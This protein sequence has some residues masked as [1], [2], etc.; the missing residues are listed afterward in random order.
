MPSPSHASVTIDGMKF[1]ALSTHVGL[2]TTHDDRGMPMMGSLTC[3][4]SVTVDMHDS[5]NLPFSTLQQLFGFANGVVSSKVKPIKIEYW[6]DE[7]QTDAL[8]VY[9][10]K[11]WVSN[12]STMSGGGANHILSLSLQPAL[13]TKNFTDLQISN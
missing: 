12:F 6:T 7:T 3:S 5:G 2:S 8:C 4:I 9:Q 10:F 1:D 11:G 13:D